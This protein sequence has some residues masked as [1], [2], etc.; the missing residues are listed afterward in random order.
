MGYHQNKL[1]TET[2]GE[3]HSISEK[4]PSAWESPGNLGCPTLAQG[5][6]DRLI[7]SDIW[8]TSWLIE[9]HHL[10]LIC[11]YLFIHHDFLGFIE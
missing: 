5:T 1:A 6:Q 3:T 8:L 10:F 9:Y 7:V 11:V 4:H 2:R